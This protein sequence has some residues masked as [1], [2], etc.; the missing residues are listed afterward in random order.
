M[1]KT[2]LQAIVGLTIVTAWIVALFVGLYNH[3]YEGLQLVT[4]IMLLYAGYM[5]GDALFQKR[6]K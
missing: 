5:F 6:D 1:H 2:L 4:P 3:D